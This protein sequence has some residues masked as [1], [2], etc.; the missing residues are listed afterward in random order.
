[1]ANLAAE[2]QNFL[3]DIAFVDVTI[4]PRKYMNKNDKVCEVYTL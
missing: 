2:R 4:Q 3:V 1:M